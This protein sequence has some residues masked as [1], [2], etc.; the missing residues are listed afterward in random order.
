VLAP[1]AAERR[2]PRVRPGDAVAI[3]TP[4]SP[5]VAAWPHRAEHARRYLESL[6]LRTK[7]M[8]HARGRDGWVAAPP[9]AC[10]A[11][12][13]DSFLDEE[14][15]VVLAATGGNYSN[16]LL[17]L[18]DFDLIR[19]HPKVFQGYSDITVLHWAILKHAGLATFHGPA[20][21]GELGEHPR[22]LDYTSESLRRA[23]FATEPPTFEPAD[24]WT[25]EFVPWDGKQDV[26]APRRLRPSSGWVTI[27]DGSGSGPLLG[28]AIEAVCWHLKGSRSWIDPA[29]AVLFLETSPVSVDPAY[30]DSYMT[31][32]AQLG[33]FER[34]SAL[35]FGRPIRADAEQTET[36]WRVVREQTEDSGIPVLANVDL[37]HADPMLTLPLGVTAHVDAGARRFGLLECPTVEPTTVAVATSSGV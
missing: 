35:V 10:A 17:P 9:E 21:C 6:G 14:V 37:G 28:G 24:G 33:V 16:R 5:G 15:A 8:P 11:D 26:A 27:R 19:S 13:H 34:A 22:P 30:T 20:F 36:L 29:G 1:A 7:L 2:P 18:L 12:I 25:D 4:S 23:W 31:D 3:V 32:L